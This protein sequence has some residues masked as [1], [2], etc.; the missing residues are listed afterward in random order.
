MRCGGTGAAGYGYLAAPRKEYTR[1]M[2]H[3]QRQ[4]RAGT[5]AVPLPTKNNKSPLW[6]VKVCRRM[7]NYFGITSRFESKRIIQ[8]SPSCISV[9][10]TRGTRPSH[11]TARPL[12]CLS[13]PWPSA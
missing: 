7:T 1:R 2:I 9:E 11:G 12:D 10:S 6:Y 13:T 5:S 4:K 8:L 3:R